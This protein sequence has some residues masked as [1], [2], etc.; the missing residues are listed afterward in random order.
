MGRVFTNGLRDRGPIRGQVMPKTQ[1][2][3]LDASLLN[4]QHYNVSIR[5]KVEESRQ[6]SSVIPYYI[7]I[8]IYV[9]N[10][11]Q[12]ERKGANERRYL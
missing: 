2:T 7:Y 6:S 8:Y 3:V 4:T 11:K 10:I 5:G 9:Y 12:E 1:K